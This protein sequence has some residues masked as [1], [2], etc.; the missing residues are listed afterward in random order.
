MR[1]LDELSLASASLLETKDGERRS[2]LQTERVKVTRTP[3]NALRLLP[4]FS[5]RRRHAQSFALAGETDAIGRA[6]A[7]VEAPIA[8]TGLTL[9]FAWLRICEGGRAAASVDGLCS[10][11]RCSVTAQ[12]ACAACSDVFRRRPWAS[13]CRISD[14]CWTGTPNQYLRYQPRNRPNSVF[15]FL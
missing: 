15:N 8:D 12:R 10:Q 7:K 1:H 3:T 6:V 2:Y 13:T 14:W 9:Q 5:L 4:G 11:T